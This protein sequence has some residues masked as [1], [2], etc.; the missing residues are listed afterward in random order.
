M[1]GLK[2]WI[3][4]I[5]EIFPDNTDRK[6]KIAIKIKMIQLP[7]N[8]VNGRNSVCQDV[9]QIKQISII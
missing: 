9:G 5:E 7:Q 3:P 2:F 4:V 6:M 1:G 8:M